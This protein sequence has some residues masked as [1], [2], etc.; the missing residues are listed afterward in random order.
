MGEIQMAVT[1]K[2]KK[3]KVF[4]DYLI[5]TESVNMFKEEETDNAIL[6]RSIYTF[7][8]NERKQFMLVIDDS[9]YLAMQALIVQDVPEAKR[10]DVL[11][12]INE[13]H[14]QYPTVKYVLTAEGQIMTST[15]Y[16][17]HEKNL[18]PSIIIRC[19]IELLK[20]INEQHYPRIKAILE[21]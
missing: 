3:A 11:A 8:E 19:T 21:D 16:H 12:L 13:L 4:R 20:A 18:E 6:F 2:H 10:A 17:M 9:V 14:F 7:G 15:V 1:A 5:Q